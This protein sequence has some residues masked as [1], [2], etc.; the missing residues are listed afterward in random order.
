MDIMRL[1]CRG[2]P[3]DEANLRDRC[4]GVNTMLTGKV[5]VEVLKL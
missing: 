1:D 3:T 2:C 5:E 4:F